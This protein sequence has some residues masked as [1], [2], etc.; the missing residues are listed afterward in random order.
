MSLVEPRDFNYNPNEIASCRFCDFVGTMQDCKRKRVLSS[1]QEWRMLAGRDG[2]HYN[3]P[4]CG[5]LI[6]SSYLRMS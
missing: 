3:C 5:M 2:W 4:N 6:K 1:P